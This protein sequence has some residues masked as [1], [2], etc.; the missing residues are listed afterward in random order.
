M[1]SSEATPSANTPSH[2]RAGIRES[3]IGSELVL[4]QAAAALLCI[5]AGLVIRYAVD[6]AATAQQVWTWSLAIAGAPLIWRTARSILRGHFATDIVA[7]LAVVGALALGQPLAGLVVV[8]MQSGGEALERLAEGRASRA[9]RELEAA[10]P[11]TAHRLAG[12]VPTDI[13]ADAIA[14]GD[15]LL[16]RP[17]EMI[18][19]DGVVRS[20]RSHVDTATLTG[21]PVPVDATTGTTVQS[22]ALNLDGPLVLEATALAAESQYARI[23]ELVRSAQATKTPLQRIADR[24]AAWFTPLTLAVCAVAFATTGDPLRALAVLVVATPCPLILAT[25]V[26]IVGGINRSARRHV[27]VRNGSAIEQIGR[28]TVVVF[29]KTGTLTVGSPQVSGVLT[30]AGQEKQDLLRLAASV[31][32][33]SGHLLARTLVE[34]ARAAGADPVAA[35]DVVEQAGAGISGVVD[36]RA[37]NVG[38]LSFVRGLHPSAVDPLEAL[39]PGESGLRAYV[40]ID[41]VAAGIVEY[42]DQVRPGVVPFLD[43]LRA[44]GI[45]HIVLLSGDASANVDAIATSLGI[46][47]AKGDLLPGQKVETVERLVGEGEI[48]VMVGDGTNDAPALTAAT[49]GIALAAGGSG[50][51]AEAADAIILADDPTR[52]VDAIEI[53]RATMRI[54]KESIWVGLGLSTVA[55]GFAAAGFIPPT[56]GAVIQEVIDVAVI[57]NAL[58]AS[59]A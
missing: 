15:R 2:A 32:Q 51:S 17:G 16:V 41:G 27:I 56:A 14:V 36:G 11:R 45:Q 39:G 40:V 59:R 12:D 10:A 38:S 29:D 54:A 47:E 6:D 30:V 48:V 58:R 3:L 57:V 44:L 13:T 53:S 52:L 46:T 43:R 28:A 25:P 7:M 33:G 50:I 35:R 34:A 18:P 9:V 24:Y 4:A 55:M 49:V 21:E 22:G 20:G 8:L 1:V 37:V 5:L 23:V 26:A 42:A 31:E 19:C